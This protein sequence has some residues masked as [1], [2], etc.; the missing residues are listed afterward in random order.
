MRS[1]QLPPRV[2]KLQQQ[3]N[4]LPPQM[5][6]RCLPP[7]MRMLQEEKLVK[8]A[9]Q[10]ELPPRMRRRRCLPPRMRMLQGEKLSEPASQAELLLSHQ[11]LESLHA[12]VE[13]RTQLLNIQLHLFRS[14]Q[15]S[16]QQLLLMHQQQQP[17]KRPQKRAQHKKKA[18]LQR[19]FRSMKK[20]QR[21]SSENNSS[22]YYL[23]LYHLM[24]AQGFAEKLFSRLQTCNE[25]FEKKDFCGSTEWVAWK[26]TRKYKESLSERAN[27]DMEH[28]RWRYGMA[29][30][31]CGWHI[32]IFFYSASVNSR[33]SSRGFSF[34]VNY[35]GDKSVLW[36]F[37]SELDKEGF[38]KNR[39]FWDDC[40]ESMNNWLD[41]FSSNYKTTWINFQKSVS[42]SIK[43]SVN[44]GSSSVQIMVK[45]DEN[46]VDLTWV[47]RFLDLKKIHSHGKSRVPTEKTGT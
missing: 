42:I 39:F 29:N 35:L 16:I 13:H 6:P 36:L 3:Q 30:K 27:H 17:E 2:L 7:R 18:K 40:F 38:I 43:I 11:Q 21:R 44:M 47:E 19:A 34:L 10:A 5:R 37:E 25:R 4:Q 31:M 20:H 24:D 23:P 14:Q 8:A 33:L 1:Q 12:R 46:P 22:S 26:K 41:A 9:P 15:A 28:K 32:E 45:E